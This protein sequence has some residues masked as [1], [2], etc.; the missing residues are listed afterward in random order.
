MSF[1]SEHR[2]GETGFL[3]ANGYLIE[4]CTTC[5]LL[6]H[7]QKIDGVWKCRVCKSKLSFKFSDEVKSVQM[8]FQPD[9]TEKSL[10]PDKAKE[11][12]EKSVEAR[13]QNKRDRLSIYY[14]G[15]TNRDSD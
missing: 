12:Q 6:Q 9:Q 1:V 4:Y 3:D 5:T 11:L 2:S 13:K 14:S 10:S 8:P 15:E 7:H